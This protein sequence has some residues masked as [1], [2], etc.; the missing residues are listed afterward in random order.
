MHARHCSVPTFCLENI[1]T[2]IQWFSATSVID[3]K[4]VLDIV[5]K[6][7]APTGI[8][9]K[10]CAIDMAIIRGCVR[11]MGVMLA[12][13]LTKDKAEDADLLRACVRAS[14][15]QLASESSTSR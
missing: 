2:Y 7:G 9:D 1:D 3:C 15:Y 13:T 10:R 14:A 12:E 8:D 5:T 6:P 4:C 11:R